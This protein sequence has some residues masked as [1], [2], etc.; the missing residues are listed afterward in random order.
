MPLKITLKPNELLTF[1]KMDEG[2]D[3]RTINTMLESAKIEA[4][5]F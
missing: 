3:D 5:M 4:E 2:F 1:V